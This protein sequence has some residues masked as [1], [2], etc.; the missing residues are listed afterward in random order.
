[1]DLIKVLKE[2]LCPPGNG[3]HTVH[4]AKELKEDYQNKLYNNRP[5]QSEWE[6]SL[7][8]LKLNKLPILFGITSD[9]GGGIQR[10]ANWG[11]LFLRKELEDVRSTYFDLGDTKTI[12][13]FLHDKYL[14]E[15]T[16]KNAQNALYDG[17]DFPV[18]PLSIAQLTSK[19]ILENMP[20]SKMLT[21]GGDHSVSYPV[22]LEWIKAK[23]AKGIK[24]AIIH[25]D[26]HT[27]LMDHRLGVDIC[28]A[29]WAFKMLEHL[30][31]PSDMIQF[32]IRASG[33][34][35]E[36]WEKTLGVKQ[37]WNYDFDNIGSQKIADEVLISLEQKKIDEIYISFD[38]DFLDAS[39]ASS[40]GTPE[41][42]GPALH[43][44]ITIIETLGN[45]FKVTGAD[46]VEVA[47]FV[48]SYKK[49]NMSPEPFTT[50]QSASA[51]L[52]SM[53]NQMER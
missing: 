33:K 49:N 39:F 46:L 13:H 5:V 45:R 27:D 9:S 47:P 15:E 36:H 8:K 37:Y 26:A 38:I 18:S 3:V 25:F 53:L 40:T 17:K 20:D 1:M 16:I 14:N 2:I 48:T 31:S 10:G 32:G 51:I 30:E 6:K 50:L 11:P 42:N 35:K 24:V 34:P 52:K 29:S 44:A 19:E 23:R 41:D 4:T 28:F 43:D 12:P 21:L 7:E 22:C